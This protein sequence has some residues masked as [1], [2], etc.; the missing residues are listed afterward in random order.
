MPEKHLRIL[1][2]GLGDQRITF[3]DRLVNG[4]A[5]AGHELLLAL[6][7]KPENERFPSHNIH[8]L[9]A[10]AWNT[11][12]LFRITNMLALLLSRLASS[13]FRWL[14]RTIKTEKSFRQKWFLIFQLLPFTRVQAD[15][16]YFPWNSSAIEYKALYDLG[17]PVI[18]SCRGSQVNIKPHK[19]GNEIYTVNLEDS[20]RNADAVHCVSRAIMEEAC[21]YALDPLKAVIIRPAVDP[22]YFSPT[23][24]RIPNDRFTILT[25]GSLI[26]RKS[27]EDALFSVRRLVDKGINCELQIIGDGPEKARILYTIQDLE[28]N[29]R[30]KLLGRLS[31]SSVKQHLQQADV[32]LLSSLSEG[33]SNAV[34]EAMSCG[35]PV[36]TTDCG[37][38]REAVTD[39]VE[40]F[41]V[42]VR[43]PTKMGER[44]QHLL[45]DPLLRSSMGKASRERVIREFD[46][47]DQVRE[48]VNLFSKAAGST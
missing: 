44:L 47:K 42:P 34:L 8:W 20:L 16:I 6:P 40:G 29:D 14:A 27:Y 12:I 25:T 24:D 37:G 28:L 26:W 22:E 7:K 48:F 10:P 39:G 19:P 45:L 33:I 5:D 43:D 32:F 41:V 15:V 35:I 17:I 30:V 11:P 2:I 36:V 31:P 3:L 23:Q 1:I 9:W 21:R 18:I 13:R 4:L 46:Q 38:M